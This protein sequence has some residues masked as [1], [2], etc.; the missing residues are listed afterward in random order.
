LSSSA[1]SVVGAVPRGPR[2]A[3]SDVGSGSALLAQPASN[4]E[5]TSGAKKRAV[6]KVVRV[7]PLVF[8]AV[9][10]VPTFIAASESSRVKRATLASI[11]RPNRA[12]D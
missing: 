12:H 6:C 7:A 3:L 2:T 9:F 10:Q 1:A 8:Q 5:K 11:S 4:A